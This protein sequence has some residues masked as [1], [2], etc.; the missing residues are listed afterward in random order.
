MSE[1]FKPTQPV[2]GLVM[3]LPGIWIDTRWAP[4]VTVRDQGACRYDCDYGVRQDAPFI[5]SLD[6]MRGN[7]SSRI[8]IGFTTEDEAYA[9]TNRIVGAIN[10]GITP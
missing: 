3:V 8:L 6:F 2:A 1:F 9:E 5:L 7:A 4:S 10:R